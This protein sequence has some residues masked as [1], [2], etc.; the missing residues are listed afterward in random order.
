MAR[1]KKPPEAR[2]EPASHFFKKVRFYQKIMKSLS[3]ERYYIKKKT[4]II[5]DDAYMRSAGPIDEMHQRCD[6]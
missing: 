4:I 6:K 3:K 2:S 5:E 1:T